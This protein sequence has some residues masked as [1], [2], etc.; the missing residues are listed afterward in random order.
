VDDRALLCA[1][2]ASERSA[3]TN[4]KL[5]NLTQSLAGFRWQKIVEVWHLPANRIGVKSILPSI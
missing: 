4:P 3:K 2:M 1:A 5:P